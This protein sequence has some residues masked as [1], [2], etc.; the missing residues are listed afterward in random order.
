[1]STTTPTPVVTEDLKQISG[2]IRLGEDT[3]LKLTAPLAGD[4]HLFRPDFD[5][6][7]YYDLPKITTKKNE[8]KFHRF[9]TLLCPN[10]LYCEIP[11]CRSH[12]QA[13]SVT[14][15]NGH[16]VCAPCLKLA[17]HNQCATDTGSPWNTACRNCSKTIATVGFNIIGDDASELSCR[18][19]ENESHMIQKSTQ[20]TANGEFIIFSIL[21][22]C[23]ECE[24]CVFPSYDGRFP[25]F[26]KGHILPADIYDKLMSDPKYKSTTKSKKSPTGSPTSSDR[27]DDIDMDG[28]DEESQTGLK[29]TTTGTALT[30]DLP[31]E[32]QQYELFP[33]DFYLE[34]YSKSCTHTPKSIP[35]YM[36]KGETLYGGNACVSTPRLTLDKSLQAKFITP[37]DWITNPVVDASTKH[38]RQH[39]RMT[40]PSQLY[41]LSTM[42]NDGKDKETLGLVKTQLQP[43]HHHHLMIPPPPLKPQ[44]HPLPP[45]HPPL[46]TKPTTPSL[47]S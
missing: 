47:H 23:E 8:S 1:M 44:P 36:S 32:Y 43:Q 42:F 2:T 26:Y 18:I 27:L 10:C 19:M 14:K 17:P 5:V 35:I 28:G 15:G 13:L 4:A 9:A 7:R 16:A 30:G 12:N 25:R 21:L 33:Q 41:S 20:S 39:G 29:F 34:H 24:T 31:L 45:P 22:R 11:G 40:S 46:S 6:R 37:K 3:R 38:Q